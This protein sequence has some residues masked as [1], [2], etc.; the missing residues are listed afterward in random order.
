MIDPAYRADYERGRRVVLDRREREAR[1]RYEAWE[2]A[3]QRNGQSYVSEA[4]RNDER[5]ALEPSIA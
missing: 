4:S 3:R 1:A 5:A 2:A